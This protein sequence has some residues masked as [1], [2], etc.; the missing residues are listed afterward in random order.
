MS[1]TPE[2]FDALLRMLHPDREKAGEIY[3]GLRRRLI[4]MFEWKGCSSSCEE[5]ADEVLDRVGRKFAAGTRPEKPDAYVWGVAHHVFQELVRRE[6]R[7]RRIIE[8]GD[9]TPESYPEDEPDRRLA[10]LRACLQLLEDFQ[11]RLLLRYYEKDQRIQARKDICDELDIPMNALR[12]RVHRL[13]KKVEVCVQ[14]KL[15]N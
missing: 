2:S 6:A 3:E 12:I 5:L 8:S 7:E 14:E 9:L 11:R 15:R 13:R 1:L 10:P 4:Q